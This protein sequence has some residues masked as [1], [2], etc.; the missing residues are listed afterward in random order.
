[1]VG[2]FDS[3]AGILAP[4]TTTNK[5]TFSHSRDFATYAYYMQLGLS[6]TGA[7]NPEVWFVKVFFK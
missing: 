4:G 3:N 2:C 1:V 5:A 6:R 7:Q